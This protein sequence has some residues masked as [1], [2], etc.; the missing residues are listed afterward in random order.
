MN[1][2]FKIGDKVKAISKS[3]GQSYDEKLDGGIL[4]INEIKKTSTSYYYICFPEGISRHF[5]EID[6]IKNNN[7]IDKLFDNIIEEIYDT[8]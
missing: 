8:I 6:L 7:E 1:T 4:T 3:I 2:K 5:L